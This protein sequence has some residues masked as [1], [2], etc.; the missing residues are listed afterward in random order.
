GRERAVAGACEDDHMGVRITREPAQP[1][2][3][4]GERLAVQRV[5]RVGPVDRD[6]A[7]VA[8]LGRDRYAG[9]L[10]R[11]NSTISPVGAP[12]VKTAATPFSFSSSASSAGI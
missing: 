8:L 4:L 7:V 1:V 11:R 2:A 10:A 5:Q 12:G 9:T 3:E 6:D